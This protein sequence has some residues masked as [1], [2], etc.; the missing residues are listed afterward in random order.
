MELLCRIEF[1]P[2]GIDWTAL[3]H[4]DKCHDDE[5]ESAQSHCGIINLAEL[6][7]HSKHSVI[8]PEHTQFGRS[9]DT[10]EKNF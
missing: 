2:Q 6:S 4:N 1:P 9:D 5:P 3:K 7:I 8:Q 10:T